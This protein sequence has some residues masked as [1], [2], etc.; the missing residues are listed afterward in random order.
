MWICNANVCMQELAKLLFA[1]FSC[2]SHM[3]NILL[4]DWF[5]AWIQLELLRKSLSQTRLDKRDD[6]RHLALKYH[7]DI[8]C[9]HALVLSFIGVTH[10]LIFLISPLFFPVWA[11]HSAVWSHELVSLELN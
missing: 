4:G 3:M 11:E 2:E 9:S 6:V 8:V 1:L 7:C 10:F 5:L